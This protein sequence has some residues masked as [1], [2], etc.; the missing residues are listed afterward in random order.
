MDRI[1]VK[2]SN[3]YA[4]LVSLIDAKSTAIT[5]VRPLEKLLFSLAW[6]MLPLIVIATTSIENIA[7]RID[8]FI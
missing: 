5:V 1:P 6:T 2:D 8:N 3:K 4:L 7:A